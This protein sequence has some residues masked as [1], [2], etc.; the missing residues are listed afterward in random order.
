MQWCPCRLLG[1]MDEEDLFDEFGNYIG[2]VEDGGVGAAEP[3]VY[4]PAESH[5]DVR[6]RFAMVTVDEGMLGL[7]VRGVSVIF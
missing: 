7:Y 2:S 5:E 6:G 4:T 1:L 3:A